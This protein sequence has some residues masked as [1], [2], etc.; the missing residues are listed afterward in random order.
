MPALGIDV[1]NFPFI[2]FLGL[3]CIQSTVDSL[4]SLFFS[5]SLFQ[6]KNDGL[7]PR[8]ELKIEPS[9]LPFFLL[10]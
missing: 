7:D 3:V 4:P 10:L 2:Y 1:H 6:R 5:F 9:S 8:E